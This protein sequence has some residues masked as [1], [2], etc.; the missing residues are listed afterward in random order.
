MFPRE[1][2]FNLV[3]IDLNATRFLVNCARSVAH[4]PPYTA[5]N[6]HDE[7]GDDK[8]GV[9]TTSVHMFFITTSKS[10]GL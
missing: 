3:E 8:Y 9:Y 10:E 1:S 6:E 4:V 5:T 7:N 2:L